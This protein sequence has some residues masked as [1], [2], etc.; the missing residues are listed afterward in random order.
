[1]ELNVQ[2][3]KIY[4]MMASRVSWNTNS[5]MAERIVLMEVM[6]KIQDVHLPQLVQFTLFN[7]KCQL[8]MWWAVFV[9]TGDDHCDGD[10]QWLND[11]MIIVMVV[12]SDCMM[13]WSL[14][15]WWT[16]IAWCDDHCDGGEQW[17][18]DVMIVVMVVNSDC[19]M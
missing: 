4:V 3:Q 19:M 18:H 16:V 10:E 6:K 14:W 12:N 2:V 5:A 15:W 13:W 17:L 1:M 7:G 11:V 9:W 8:L